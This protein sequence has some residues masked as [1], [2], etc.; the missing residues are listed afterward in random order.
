MTVPPSSISSSVHL[1]G[2]DA[3]LNSAYLIA[4]RPHDS[5]RTQDTK[6]CDCSVEDDMMLMVIPT[7]PRMRNRRR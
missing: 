3:M 6:A 2:P 4:D 7:I 5:L 1:H